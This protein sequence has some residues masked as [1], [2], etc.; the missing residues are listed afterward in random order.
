MQAR[1]YRGA[2]GGF[3]PPSGNA[4]PPPPPVGE[5]WYFSSGMGLAIWQCFIAYKS[6]NWRIW[7]SYVTKLMQGNSQGI[8]LSLIVGAIVVFRID[9]IGLP[10]VPILAGRPDF[11]PMCPTSWHNPRRDVYVPI[12]WSKKLIVRLNDSGIIDR[13]NK[14]NKISVWKRFLRSFSCPCNG[15]KC[16]AAVQLVC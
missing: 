5:F 1:R 9:V 8:G 13:S 4:C 14:K 3:S 15:V 2:R 12:F 16:T 6:W 11:Q 7:K 10:P